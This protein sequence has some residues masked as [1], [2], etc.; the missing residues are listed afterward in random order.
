MPDS[1]S[2]QLLDPLLR[3]CGAQHA[4]MAVACSSS[5][6]QSVDHIDAGTAIPNRREGPEVIFPLER[7]YTV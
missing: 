2:T 6:R 3:S 1:G 5:G 4:A 7:R